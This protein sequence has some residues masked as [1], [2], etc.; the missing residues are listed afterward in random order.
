VGVV[1]ILAVVAGIFLFPF[2]EVVYLACWIGIPEEVIG[3]VPYGTVTNQ[4]P[5]QP[6]VQL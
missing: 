1:R 3:E 6:P 4:T 5:P 2:T